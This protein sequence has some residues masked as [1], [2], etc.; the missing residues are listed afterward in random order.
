MPSTSSIKNRVPATDQPSS[1]SPSK[2]SARSPVNRD[3]DHTTLQLA[4]FIRTTG[5]PANGSMAS[6][7]P[8]ALGG[9]GISKK[10]TANSVHSNGDSS[11]AGLLKYQQ[12]QRYPPSPS[13][14]TQYGTLVDGDDESDD[15]YELSMYP[16]A[17]R[18]QKPAPQ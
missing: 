13:T 10:A 2:L 3:P 12:S 4:A 1:P 7:S 6:A 14:S 15:D 8:I 11:T 16:G 17:R 5:P 18:K 9:P